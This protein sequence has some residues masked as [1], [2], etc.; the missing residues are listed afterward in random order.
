MYLRVDHCQV[1]IPTIEQ[2]YDVR[3]SFFEIDVNRTVNHFSLVINDDKTIQGE[4]CWIGY[5]L[6]FNAPNN[7][8]ATCLLELNKFNYCCGA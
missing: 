3:L 5:K 6:V 2:L 8:D 7:I 1:V 4:T